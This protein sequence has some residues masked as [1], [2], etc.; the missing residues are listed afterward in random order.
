M[1]ETE[2]RLLPQLNRIRASGPILILAALFLI[3]TFLAWYFTW[4]GR[5]LSDADV[6]KY[7]NDT[8]NPRHVQHALLQ[9]QQRID[10]GDPSAKNW[11]P[12]ILTLSSSPETEYRLTVAWLMGFD[13]RS[14]EFHNSLLTLVNDNEPI[15]RRNAALALVRF[16]DDRGHDE[17]VAILKPFAVKSIATGVVSSTLRAGSD[18][19]RGTLLGRVE[20]TDGKVIEIR[21]SLPGKIEQIFKANGVQV[22]AGDEILT[23]NS[24]E[25]SVWEGLRGLSFIGKP[26]DLPLV[27]SYADASAVTQRVKE[28]AKLTANAIQAKR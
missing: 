16:N 9:I 19:S 1:T 2:T 7:L 20:Q 23:L 21:S 3:A 28:Q 10:R 22:N 26:A 12:Q 4:F 15:V 24:D 11:Y 13:N 17:L 18:V 25:A 8:R 6:S 5:G 14:T 27:Q